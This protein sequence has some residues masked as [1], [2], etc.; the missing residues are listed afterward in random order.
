[1]KT[2]TR[3]TRCQ[4]KIEVITTK[5]TLFSYK[6]DKVLS[7]VINMTR[8]TLRFLWAY[9]ATKRTKC[10]P[11]TDNLSERADGQREST[12]VLSCP[13]LPRH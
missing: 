4:K 6:A 9:L 7:E 2:D 12:S 8:T 3:R 11:Y 5:R 13:V 1:M 10:P